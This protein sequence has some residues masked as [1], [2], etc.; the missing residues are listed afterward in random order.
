[1]LSHAQQ[2]IMLADSEKFGV[3]GQVVFDRPPKLTRIIT[4]LAPDDAIQ[5]NI[6]ERGYRLTI[7]SEV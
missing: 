2:P 6:A 4:D 7:V 1:M 5:Q 3:V